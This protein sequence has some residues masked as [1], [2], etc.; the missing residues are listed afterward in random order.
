MQVETCSN[1]HDA[2]AICKAITSGYFYNTAKFASNAEYKTIKNQH[3]VYIHPSS[4]MA[5]VKTAI[6]HCHTYTP[7]L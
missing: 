3:T 7:I 6:A 4:V 1:P 5:K 2:E